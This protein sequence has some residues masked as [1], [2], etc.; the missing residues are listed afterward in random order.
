GASPLYAD[1]RGRTHLHEMQAGGMLTRADPDNGLPWALTDA[2]EGMVAWVTPEGEFEVARPG[3]TLR[4]VG[5][6]Y[7]YLTCRGDSMTQ[8]VGSSSLTAIL[9]GIDA[10]P[11]AGYPRELQR[12]LLAD[13]LPVTVINRGSASAMALDIAARTVG[14]YG[15]AAQFGAV[16]LAG[17]TYALQAMTNASPL[18]TPS[19]ATQ[20][21]RGRLGEIAGTLYRDNSPADWQSNRRAYYSFTP[22]GGQR[23]LEVSADPINPRRVYQWHPEP[24]H[25]HQPAIIWIGR[26]NPGEPAQTVTALRAMLSDLP[27]EVPR[28]VIGVLAAT[29]ESWGNGRETIEAHNRAIA[30]VAGRAFLDPNDVLGRDPDGSIRADGTPRPAYM[31]DD[32]H[33][34]DAGYN[35]LAATFL[36]RIQSER[37]FL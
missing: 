11:G 1:A 28:L 5:R 37:W 31:S 20:H 4:T 8:G 6:L 16:G 22:D 32:L 26:N 7:R 24:I 14:G 15:A 34:N 35:V 36:A 9:P 25:P 18:L 19:R 30:E 29:T 33:C 27:P 13:G 21:Q 10:A 3:L 2:A 17:G 23:A 12:L